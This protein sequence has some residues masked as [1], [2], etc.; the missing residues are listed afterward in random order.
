MNK[1]LSTKEA[2]TLSAKL[3]QQG[4]TIVLT[5]G[6]F[7]ILHVGHIAYLEEAKK[8]GDLLFVFLEDDT[9]IK[10]TKGDNRPLNTQEDRAKI[11]AALS[12]VDYIIMLAPIT[13]NTVYDDLVIQIK[14]A[15]IAAT[16]GDPNRHHKERQAKMIG[17]KV[18][19]VISPIQNKST[20][21]LINI[22][23]EI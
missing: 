4:K 11:L 6:C 21:K 15:I 22:L 5:G 16:Q 20:T 1:I 19:D 7:D 2:I 17:A 12:V 18:V 10:K 8:L 3:H 14:P 9:R 13:D 23:N